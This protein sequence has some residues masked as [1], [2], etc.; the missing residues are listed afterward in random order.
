MDQG[1]TG[2]SDPLYKPFA[3]ARNTIYYFLPQSIFRLFNLLVTMG[4]SC[5]LFSKSHTTY[6]TVILFH[7]LVLLHERSLSFVSFLASSDA[8]LRL[9]DN[10]SKSFLIE[11]NVIYNDNHGRDDFPWRKQAILVTKGFSS[12]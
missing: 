8:M 3:L 7:T 6:I 1:S 2:V 10:Y 4:Q 12:P 9:T 5:T 11:V